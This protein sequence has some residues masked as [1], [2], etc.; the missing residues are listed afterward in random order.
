MVHIC[1]SRG[2][3]LG[4]PILGHHPVKLVDPLLPHVDLG[5]TADEVGKVDMDF[6]GEDF[7]VTTADL[8]LLA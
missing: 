1:N 6:P 7:V 2:G 3:F 8:G 4:S 5:L